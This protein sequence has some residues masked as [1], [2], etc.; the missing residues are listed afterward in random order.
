MRHSRSEPG[1]SCASW[2]RSAID[3]LI[4]RRARL[5]SS[6]KPVLAG[7][8]SIPRW[9]LDL[10]KREN[11]MSEQTTEERESIPKGS[12]VSPEFDDPEWLNEE[13]AR[14]E[15]ENE[16]LR[17]EIT[18]PQ[19]TDI[20]AESLASVLRASELYEARQS[21]LARMTDEEKECRVWWGRAEFLARYSSAALM[22]YRKLGK[23]DLIDDLVDHGILE[24]ELDAGR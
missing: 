14:L 2:L 16:R 10:R 9:G 6:P 1:E 7:A 20:Q 3:G 11:L 17:S 12:G 19:R 13:A 5:T 24:D 15:R 4:Q 22:A 21:A 23:W 8:P 18:A